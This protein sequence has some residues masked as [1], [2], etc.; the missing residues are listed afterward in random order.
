MG[1]GRC[2]FKLLRFGGNHYASRL[3]VQVFI[4]TVLALEMSR[5]LLSGGGGGGEDIFKISLVLGV[6][7]CVPPAG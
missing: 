2:W 3:S 6:R 7:V 4:V 1:G 5:N